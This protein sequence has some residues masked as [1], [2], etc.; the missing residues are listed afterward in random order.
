[1]KRQAT[2][3]GKYLH[4]QGGKSRKG[5]PPQRPIFIFYYHGRPLCVSITVSNNGFVIGMNPRSWR[6][7]ASEYGITEEDLKKG[8]K[9]P[10]GEDA[11]VKPSCDDKHK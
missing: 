1:M 3:V 6:D 2:T 4:D 5:Q 9:W 11:T 10:I 7:L 8:H